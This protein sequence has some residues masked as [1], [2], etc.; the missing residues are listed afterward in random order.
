[1]AYYYVTGKN[2]GMCEITLHEE[3]DVTKTGSYRI[4]AAVLHKWLKAKDIAKTWP[5]LEDKMADAAAR[6]MAAI[7]AKKE[8][9][10]S[11]YC[12]RHAN[13]SAKQQRTNYNEKCGKS[14]WGWTEVVK[15]HFDWCMSL[16]KEVFVLKAQQAYRDRYAALRKCTGIK[17]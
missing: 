14:G 10:Q 11:K 5:H 3:P 12:R 15:S 1:M 8:K 16:P 6:R 7:L 17:N 9:D 4:F 13:S 2:A